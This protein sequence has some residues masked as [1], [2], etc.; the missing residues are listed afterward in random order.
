MNVSNSIL[1]EIF[2]LRNEYNID[3][4]RKQFYL[5]DG[6]TKKKH[7]LSEKKIKELTLR[8][9]IN[10]YDNIEEF[11]FLDSEEQDTYI[12]RKRLVDKISKEIDIVDKYVYAFWLENNEI[13]VGYTEDWKVDIIDKFYDKK[14]NVLSLICMI[15]EGD[16]VLKNSLYIYYGSEYGFNK[17]Y[18]GIFEKECDWDKEKRVSHLKT[19]NEKGELIEEKSIEL[20]EIH[21]MKK[22]KYKGGKPLRDFKKDIVEDIAEEKEEEP[23]AILKGNTAIYD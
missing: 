18:G 4:I 5:T 8:N 10:N 13:L 19:L 12:V 23:P 3:E 16:I 6:K 21:E 20:V 9:L 15:P 2:E 11:D 1:T 22:G 14:Y 7:Y 17:V